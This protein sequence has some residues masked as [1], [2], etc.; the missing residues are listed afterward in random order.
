MTSAAAANSESF[1]LNVLSS[2]KLMIAGLL[3]ALA[4]WLFYAH[5]IGLSPVLFMLALG[6]GA[7]I[8]NPEQTDQRGSLSGAAILLLSVTPLLV[9]TSL[10]GFIL[11]TSG[12]AYAVVTAMHTDASRC[13][14]LAG[15][16]ALLSN[17]VWRAFSDVFDRAHRWRHSDAVGESGR[18][19]AA[20]IVPL[21]LGALF[22]ALFSSAN[23][24][25]ESWLGY[26]DLNF[27]LDQVSISRVAFWIAF[28]SLAWPFIVIRRHMRTRED[29][30]AVL[31][32]ASI[33]FPAGSLLAQMLGKAAILRSLILFNTIFAVQTLLD[34]AYL[35]GGVT[36]PDGMSYA[37]YAHRGAYP[38]ILTTLLA[39]LFVIVTTRPGSEAERSPLIRILVI[40]WIGQNVLLVISSIL[41]L[42]LY[43][44][45]Y[46]LTYWRVAAFVWMALV[47]VGLVLIVARMI[48]RRSNAWLIGMNLGSLAL[49]LYICS[50]VNFPSLIASFNVAHSKVSTNAGVALDLNYLMGLGAHALPAFDSHFTRADAA[51]EGTQSSGGKEIRVTEF[52]HKRRNELAK[53]H[54]DRMKD[55]RAWTYQ[56]WQLSQ[57]LARHPSTTTMPE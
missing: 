48:M 2:R 50:F 26:I 53:A 27:I 5:P 38:L 41:R 56:D 4:D 23:P 11:A 7:L 54:L 3:V 46:S 51:L 32:S 37:S 19:L 30:E 55:W 22:V 13:D 52:W 35:W 28:L 21:L 33:E 34:T 25:I 15:T 17:C 43:V 24:L 44:E 9:R 49:A 14:R 31:R 57:Y 6:A 8:A 39:A 1:P 16:V 47:A 18:T 45:A 40:V 36:L 10:P 12:T 20:W 29:I 42:N